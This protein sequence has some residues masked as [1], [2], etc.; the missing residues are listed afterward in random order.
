[1]AYPKT[2]WQD[3]VRSPNG[4]TWKLQQNADGTITLIPAWTTIQAGT[5]ESASNFNNI[6]GGIDQATEIGLELV[7]VLK[8]LSNDVANDNP[9]IKT[10]TLA[11]TLTYP[12]N[13][14]E[15]TVAFSGAE[16]RNN[17]DYTV[18][19]YVVSETGGS[20]GRV[21]VRDKLTN[22]FKVKYTGGAA[23][24]ALKLAITGGYE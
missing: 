10:V 11:N 22:G 20:F 18:D 3:E 6:E 9:T 21:I 23:S 19:A 1:M 5:P 14:S 2:S 12:F 15:I 4:R 16:V 13:S 17:L 8:L 7:R 24:V